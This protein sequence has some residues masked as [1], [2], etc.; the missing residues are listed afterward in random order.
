[1]TNAIKCP[2]ESFKRR[3]AAIT[4]MPRKMRNP[5]SFPQYI[6][7]NP[8][9]NHSISLSLQKTNAYA[10]CTRNI[11]GKINNNKPSAHSA[12]LPNATIPSSSNSDDF[13]MCILFYDLLYETERATAR[14]HGVEHERVADDKEDVLH[15]PGSIHRRKMPSVSI[16]KTNIQNVI[17][18]RSSV[19]SRAV[20]R[21]LTARAMTASLIASAI[22]KT[23][24]GQRYAQYFNS[25][26]SRRG[27]F[28]MPGVIVV[29][30]H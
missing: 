24:R 15:L 11:K 12:I 7:F 2:K 18:R 6:T 1:M 9:L 25:H 21:S 17:L 8:L 14:R 20:S 19:F 26:V 5:P 13:F 4:N 10:N 22:T 29:C 3:T 28:Y 23:F 30:C 16:R 27:I